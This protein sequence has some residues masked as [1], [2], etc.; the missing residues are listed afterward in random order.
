MRDNA[1][2]RLAL[3]I[4][5]TGTRRSKGTIHDNDGINVPY[6]MASAICGTF[7]G[8]MRP[9]ISQVYKNFDYVFELSQV[10]SDK[11]KKVLLGIWEYDYD[12]EEDRVSARRI[13]AYDFENGKWSWNGSSCEEKLKKYP[14]QRE[15]IK[16]ME[17]ML[18][19]LSEGNLL[20]GNPKVYPAYYS[21]RKSFGR[22]G[23]TEVI[24]EE[25]TEERTVCLG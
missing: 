2:F 17:H 15:L 13:C 12:M 4:T 10:P 9:L 3:D 22:C 23:S 25:D 24:S 21:S 20:K 11:S 6:K 5:S 1:A 7:G 8:N 19:K 16:E 14:E 18:K